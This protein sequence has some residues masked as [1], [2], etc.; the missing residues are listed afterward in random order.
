MVNFIM[1]IGK[2]DLC[3]VKERIK[4]KMVWDQVNGMKAD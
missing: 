1:D 2:M 3:M 4:I